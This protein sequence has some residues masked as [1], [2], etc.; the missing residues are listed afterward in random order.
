M[1]YVE[2]FLSE[3]IFLIPYMLMA[4]SFLSVIMPYLGF[5]FNFVTWGNGGG[6]SL[7]TDILFIRVFCFNK[8]YCWLTRKLPLSFIFIN[9]GNIL[10]NEFYPRYYELYGQLYEITIFSVT[11]FVFLIFLIEKSLKK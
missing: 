3:T 6:F 9:I 11:L 5:D 2:H 8:K 10:C 4:V 1:K 7:I